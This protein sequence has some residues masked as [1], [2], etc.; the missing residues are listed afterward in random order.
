M[1]Q[2]MIMKDTIKSEISNEQEIKVRSEKGEQAINVIVTPA[3][4]RNSSNG[5]VIA[6]TSISPCGCNT[7]PRL[8]CT[9][10]IEALAEEADKAFIWD[11]F[12]IGKLATA[13]F[14]L[15]YVSLLIQSDSVVCEIE[16]EDISTEIA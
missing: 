7:S 8:R 9:N 16:D 12:D 10:D 15:E 14:K 6:G 3:K 1:A 4:G 2:E 11:N 13:G 5:T